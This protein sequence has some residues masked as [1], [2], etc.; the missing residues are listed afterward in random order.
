MER[1]I[2]NR[3]YYLAETRAGFVPSKLASE[4]VAPVKIEFYELRR[5]SATAT[6]LH[7]P[8]EQS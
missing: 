2:H 4:R 3:L 5:Q 1:M 7:S 6:K 8:S